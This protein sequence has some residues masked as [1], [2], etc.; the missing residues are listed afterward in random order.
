MSL[1]PTATASAATPIR[2]ATISARAVRLPWPISVLLVSRVADPSACILTWAVEM[3]EAPASLAVTA[4]ARPRR[5]PGSLVLAC[6]SSSAATASRSA[7]RSASSPRLPS[8]IVPPGGSR[9]RR[10]SSVGSIPS[11]SAAMS[12]FSSPARAPWG[13]P[14]PRYDEA[15]VVLVYT[16]VPLTRRFGT[17]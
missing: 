9:L 16:A 15:G 12:M 7:V 8:M 5:T 1:W 2:R 4:T 17:R 3:G 11:R 6:R 13:A 10:R 14:N